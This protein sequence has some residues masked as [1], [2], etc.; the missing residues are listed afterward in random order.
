ME[1]VTRAASKR[2]TLL[3]ASVALGFLIG[4]LPSSAGD[5][6]PAG[7]FPGEAT[8][9][10]GDPEPTFCPAVPS[11]TCDCGGG[12]SAAPAGGGG[13]GGA[14][15]GGA[16]SGLRLAPSGA[17]SV[18]VPATGSGGAAPLSK[19]V[20]AVAGSEV[21]ER[22]DLVVPGV[23][24]IELRR[25]YDAQ[26]RYD[27]PLGYGWAWRSYDLRL[28]EYEDDSVVVRES[29]GYRHR[30]VP[31]SGG[32]IAE[33]ARQEK[34]EGTLG[35]TWILTY[36]R[37]ERAHFNADGLLER[38]EDPNGNHLLFQYKSGRFALTGTSPAAIDPAA[39]MVVA[40]VYQLERIDEVLAQGGGT[41][42]G[43]H[44]ILAYDGTTG[45][46]QSVTAWDGRA[47]T[48]DHTDA[49]DPQGLIGDLRVVNG[50]DGIQSLYGYDG[51]HNLTSVQHGEGT[52]PWVLT[53]DG[54]DRVLSQ[55]RGDRVVTFDYSDPL[56]TVVTRTRKDDQ[57]V[58]LT[59]AVDVFEYTPSG[60]LTKRIDALGHETRY[61]LDAQNLRRREEL[62]ENIGTVASP[63]FGPSPQK[64]VD[65]DYDLDGNLVERVVVLDAGGPPPETVTETWTYDHHWVASYQVVSSAAPAKVFR[66]EW[67]FIKSGGV[68]V[69]IQ[70]VK[71]LRDTGAAFQSTLFTYDANGQLDTI[72][73]PAV[74][75][76]D[77]L[78]I[79]RTYYGSGSA[80]EK[81]GLV[82]RE[83]LLVGG[84]PD[85]HLKRSF[86][87]DSRGFLE[88]VTDARGHTTTF[89]ND[90]LGRVTKVTNHL[91]ES[92]LYTYAGPNEGPLGDDPATWPKGEHLAQVEAGQ[93]GTE[94]EGQLQRLR[95][96]PEG[97]LVAIE[98]KDD[99]E[100]WSTFVAYAYDSDDNRV[101]ETDGEN[102]TT[103]F[104][105]DL[106]GQMVAIEDAATNVT[107][108]A[109]DAAGN[110]TRVTDA[111][112]R[113]TV[114]VYDE[115]DR[116]V[117][118]RAE[119]FSPNLVTGFEYDA[120]GNVTKV[121]DPKA[122]ETT[123][124]YSSLSELTSVTQHL[125]Q[126]VTYTY[127]GRGRLARLTNARGN[128]LDYTYEPW[129]GLQAVEDYLT[130][131]DANQGVNLQRKIAYE[132]DESGNV[133]ATRDTDLAG[134]TPPPD[135]PPLLEETT[136]DAL[137][138]PDVVT[139]HYVPNQTT[140]TLTH[141][142]DR[143]GN[144]KRL[145]L[146]DDGAVKV[147]TWTY[148]DLD[149]LEEAQLASDP[150]E[151]DYYGND[152]LQQ[153][154]R[155]PAGS[156][157][158]TTDYTYFPEGPI[159][160]ITV[161]A[162]ASQLLKLT[163]VVDDVLNIGTV[164][165]EHG[166]GTGLH[167]YDYGYDDLDRLTSAV[168]PTAL[169][170]GLPASESFEYDPAG[171]RELPGQPSVYDYDAN[172]RI[173]DSPGKTWTYD[174]DG[175]PL[176]TT[177][178][179]TFTYN[180]V[181]RMVGYADG[182]TTASY[183]YD[184][185]GRRIRKT[186]GSTETW[187]LWDGGQLLAEFDGAGTRERRYTYSH[188]FAPDEQV[189][190]S[191]SEVVS[192]VHVDH[193]N[194]PRLLTQAG[195]TVWRATYEAFGV[196]HV[197]E[198]GA[199]HA[200]RFPG[201]YE[202]QEDLGA[203]Y[204]RLR[205]YNPDVGRYL[206]ADPIGQRGAANIFEYA[207][208]RPLGVTDMLGLLP[209]G[210]AGGNCWSSFQ[211]AG[212]QKDTRTET[213]VG[214]FAL[215]DAW[216]GD[217]VNFKGHPRYQVFCVYKRYVTTTTTELER[218]IYVELETCIDCDGQPKTRV[219]DSYP[220]DWRIVDVHV[221]PKPEE[222]TVKKH[223]ALWRFPGLGRARRACQELTE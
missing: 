56:R 146:D 161:N 58:A 21:F 68:P 88:S 78:K 156:P 136:Y 108:F 184:P 97:R 99:D 18:S 130:A 55:S 131:A 124:A 42:T 53:Y 183:L 101:S 154:R 104:A 112:D 170:G 188:A 111:L 216:W 137:D 181:N 215:Q 221:F 164:T 133:T 163:Y 186:V 140:L 134:V 8:G 114:L 200:V 196:A 41:P 142:Y 106:L 166:V 189:D 173:V 98:R 60:H 120:A 145:E 85:P 63:A 209:S 198:T 138:R 26:S 25:R 102:R 174:D 12:G 210:G 206:S 90:A 7:S 132:Y 3:I 127:D 202:D 14:P 223:G 69:N 107:T 84:S 118:S 147:H 205:Y 152:D 70:Q 211:L 179:E 159:E 139:I 19:P 121:V 177:A 17:S 95:W 86:D 100:N 66:T 217:R 148:N 149:Q 191:L 6:P 40:Q 49:Q 32:Y 22:T 172:N 220:L 187:F 115:L 89:E 144:R 4:A 64:G 72:T 73:P 197:T 193:L 47:V 92:T 48:Y 5:R 155:G 143:F 1:K 24:P 62:W 46:L 91:Q 50:L 34:L 182:S 110:R 175:N 192:A 13:G 119:A 116:L 109:Y 214:D 222:K 65:F 218:F 10:E 150:L 141:A 129:G 212:P 27:S 219:V 158:T 57:G 103:T 105:Y 208:S 168:Y 54:Q 128:A 190:G 79:K 16:A 178:G 113:E 59:P 203:Y 38:L 31:A 122:Q 83:E 52:T 23:F 171:N 67:T 71:R 75:P 162:G 9:G 44:V 77:G 117:E 157:V 45:R 33:G 81:V 167:V 36:P 185:F 199:T 135:P 30:F 82:E 11:P 20:N 194:T 76:S 195:S 39:P 165:E 29:C 204:N 80:T 125:N 176:S 61:T 15:G 93:T 2:R 207:E 94:G 180:E 74:V 160:T 201:Q 213:E 123:Y 87:Y 43:R 51:A 96:D 153:I 126:E 37:G 28:Y 169:H 35:G 151:F